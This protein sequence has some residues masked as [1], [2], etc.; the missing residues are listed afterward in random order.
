MTDNR[1]NLPRR[2]QTPKSRFRI[3]SRTLDR[4]MVFQL[5]LKEDTKN[6]CA[7]ATCS[8]E[9]IFKYVTPEELNAFENSL[10]EEDYQKGLVTE[11]PKKR[12]RPLGSSRLI[13]PFL[14]KR[15]KKRGRPPGI[16]IDSDHSTPEIDGPRTSSKKISIGPIAIEST[17]E[18]SDVSSE[19]TSGD[20]L[21]N[22]PLE[23]T[24]ASEQISSDPTLATMNVS[25]NITSDKPTEWEREMMARFGPNEPSRGPLQGSRLIPFPCL[26]TS[27]YL[28]VLRR[29]RTPIT[30]RLG[31]KLRSWLRASQKL[32]GRLHSSPKISN[33]HGL[34]AGSTTTATAQSSPF[35]TK[36]RSRNHARYV[37]KHF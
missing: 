36:Q 4:D 34:E 22:L 14:E 10:F 37:R 26:L 24:S 9:D 11:P 31:S 25:S 17:E 29:I 8:L 5:G 1:G 6:V 19:S 32:E 12:G 23:P 13:H 20:E 7:V 18:S 35:S 27:S 2:N 30:R 15:P 21:E 16:P 28:H 33:L 3:L